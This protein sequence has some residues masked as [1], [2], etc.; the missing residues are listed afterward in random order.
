MEKLGDVIKD[1]AVKT[2]GEVIKR[3]RRAEILCTTLGS[4]H[5]LQDRRLQTGGFVD[6][7][8]HCGIDVI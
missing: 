2:T 4:C 3:R 5:V 6:V 7:P 1:V 8:E